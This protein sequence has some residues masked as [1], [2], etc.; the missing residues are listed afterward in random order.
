MRGPWA[1]GQGVGGGVNVGEAALKPFFGDPPRSKIGPFG[2]WRI[3][4]DYFWEV[5]G[6]EMTQRH[7]V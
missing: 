1:R 2:V 4:A 5:E 3:I 7:Q 6:A